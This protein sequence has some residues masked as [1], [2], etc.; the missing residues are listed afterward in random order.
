M[1]PATFVPRKLGDF[2]LVAQLS[3]DA[4]G[5]VYRA[6]D[7]SD[8]G[9]FFRLRILQS[10]ELSPD[11]VAAAIA[12]HASAVAALSHK[13]I[14]QRGRVGV[15][16]GAP[17][18]AWQESG[19][20]T[21]D[22]VLSKLR[23]AKK[24]IPLPYALLI[25]QRIA[26]ALEH[27]WYSVVDGEPTRHG[28]LWP[29]FVAISPDA[30]IR[31]G[32]FGVADAVLP[33]LHKPRLARDI[34]PYVP[35][36]ARSTGISG[37]NADVY[38]AAVILAEIAGGR[39]AGAAPD[40]ADLPPEEPLTEP[41]RPVLHRALAAPG[42][43]FASASDLNRALQELLAQN[44]APISTGELALFLYE[45]LNPE[46]RSVAAAVDGDSTN[47]VRVAEERTSAAPALRFV[48]AS[49]ARSAAAPRRRRI[50]LAAILATAAIAL[51]AVFLWPP[52]RRQSASTGSPPPAAAASP[53]AVALPPP[54]PA[55]ES[56][57]SVETARPA[58]VRRFRRP[59][60]AVR[61]DRSSAQPT[62]AEKR[63]AAD[64]ARLEAG[65]ARVAAERLAAA[66]LASAPF[67]EAR[68]REQAGEASL[69]G[70]DAAAAQSEF[71]RAASLFREAEE[72]ARQER[73]KRVKL[74]D[75]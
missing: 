65:L 51:A 15:A 43:R 62:P 10:P 41:L 52:G 4:L 46:S 18:L 74:R 59:R 67:S 5:T 26:A 66:E 49:A 9:R 28:L 63:T 32:G 60:R 48:P 13:A 40:L 58:A 7:E 72:L 1:T 55:L 33:A 73:I 25:A 12:R 45:L 61:V 69:R 64:A 30:E 27:A 34:A 36:E 19:G 22:F 16:D 42:E 70:G 57:P 75:D 68:E 29:G 39:R 50:A 6:L 47:P 23:A 8:E 20:W 37:E 38:S 2:R 54:P 17:Y 35:P 56:R 53:A 31:V 11:D 3:D 44:H 14:V 21:L 71:G 24:R